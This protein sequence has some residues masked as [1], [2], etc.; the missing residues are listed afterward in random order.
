M[1]ISIDFHCICIMSE[2]LQ[3][4]VAFYVYC[5]KVATSETNNRLVLL[6]III[7]YLGMN[8]I[9]CPGIM[10]RIEKSKQYYLRTK[11]H[12]VFNLLRIIQCC[13]FCCCFGSE[14][15]FNKITNYWSSSVPPKG[16]IFGKIYKNNEMCRINFYL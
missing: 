3:F 10:D 14:I 1:W 5:N 9:W 7:I 11:S 4:Y 16:G 6:E 13:C 12:T 8:Y 2:S 15:C